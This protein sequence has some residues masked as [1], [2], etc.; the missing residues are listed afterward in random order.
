[1][2]SST[3]GLGTVASAIR[4]NTIAKVRK[5]AAMVE[6]RISS[7]S[8]LGRAPSSSVSFI[9]RSRNIA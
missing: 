1:M 4:Q 5:R 7:A 9:Q 8:S 6:R 3:N 2:F